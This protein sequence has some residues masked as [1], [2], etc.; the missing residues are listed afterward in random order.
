MCSTDVVIKFNNANYKVMEE[1]KDLVVRA[2]MQGH[3]MVL[4]NESTVC[5]C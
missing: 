1:I 3:Q 4:C 5:I 2:C